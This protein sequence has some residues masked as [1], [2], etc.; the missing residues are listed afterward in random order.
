MVWLIRGSSLEKRLRTILGGKPSKDIVGFGAELESPRAH[1]EDWSRSR[2][3]TQNIIAVR[4]R[5]SI[6]E[7]AST[8]LPGPKPNTQGPGQH[9]WDKGCPIPNLSANFQM[10]DYKQGVRLD[11]IILAPYLENLV[12]KPMTLFF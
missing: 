4:T 9:E 10:L 2:L 6:R 5:W 7:R 8:S 1:P 3:R 11:T 12:F